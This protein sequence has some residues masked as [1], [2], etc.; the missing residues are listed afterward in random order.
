MHGIGEL[1]DRA[2]CTKAEVM[3]SG[4]GAGGWASL[5]EAGGFMW[6]NTCRRSSARL[7]GLGRVSMNEEECLLEGAVCLWLQLWLPVLVPASSGLG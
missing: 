4:S 2:C 7:L 3:T 6:L 5:S 1:W